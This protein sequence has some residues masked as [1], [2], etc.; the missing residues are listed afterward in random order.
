MSRQRLPNRRASE[1]FELEAG[2]LRYTCTT[3]RLADGKI[4]ELFLSN[5]KANSA[6]DTN[7]RD[8]AIVFS[9]AVQ[10]GADAETI[11]HARCAG[12][13]RGAHQGHWP[14]RSTSWQRTNS[15]DTA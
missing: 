3:S 9:I 8:S 12:T 15:R 5:H 4:F 2:K 13:H 6:A 10:S 1:T 7:A 11:R 14:L